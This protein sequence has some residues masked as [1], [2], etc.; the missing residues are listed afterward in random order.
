M[1]KH[2]V[3]VRVLDLVLSAIHICSSSLTHGHDMSPTIIHTAM[4]TATGSE[5]AKWSLHIHIPDA[6]KLPLLV[7]ASGLRHCQP[8]QTVTLANIAMDAVRNN[9]GSCSAW[10]AHV[11]PARCTSN[12]TRPNATQ[13]IDRE[14]QQVLEQVQNTKKDELQ[15]QAWKQSFESH[16]NVHR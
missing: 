15:F 11:Q 5:R 6:H 4:A 9:R 10:G 16:G 3:T 1:R 7:D 12:A 2:C 14:L 13:P 8:R